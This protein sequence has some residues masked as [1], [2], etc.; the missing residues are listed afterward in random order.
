MTWTWCHSKGMERNNVSRMSGKSCIFRP[1]IAGFCRW[2]SQRQ[3]LPIAF[4]TACGPLGPEDIS[5]QKKCFFWQIQCQDRPA[6]LGRILNYS[7]LAFKFTRLVVGLLCLQ[8]FAG[9]SP[10]EASRQF[11]GM[12]PASGGIHLQDLL[13]F[14]CCQEV[15]VAKMMPSLYRWLANSP[16]HQP[17]LFRA[18]IIFKK[19]WRPI[20]TLKK[21][22]L[23]HD[24][25]PTLY[26]HIFEQ[27]LMNRYR[28]SR[29]FG[30]V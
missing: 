5:W 30:A 9:E 11:P 7:R 20:N 27:I 14:C 13:L 21:N 18:T 15:A 28:I 29:H 23:V 10:G 4:K 16:T 19:T 3:P 17:V 6:A 24:W 2:T 12:G 1:S 26:I 22:V 8:H 25:C